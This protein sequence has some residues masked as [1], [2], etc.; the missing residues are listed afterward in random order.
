MLYDNLND[1]QS[2]LLD[3]LIMY[4]GYGVYVQEVRSNE[5][6]VTVIELKVQRPGR[7]AK[8]EWVKLTDP[9]LRYM[10]LTVGY[11]NYNG[12]SKWFYRHPVRQYR[13]GLRGEQLGGRDES[14]L[15]V[16][17]NIRFNDLYNKHSC[18]AEML[19]NKYPTIEEATKK[20]SDG[21]ATKVGFHKNFALYR[22]KFRKD[23]V[24]EYK[25]RPIAVTQ[26]VTGHCEPVEE[27]RFLREELQRAGIKVK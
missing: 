1:A 21:T 24:V 5:E 13:Q 20:V 11:V 2:K 26:D 6:D 17:Y 9:K 19:E 22:D 8:G 27:F 15:R 4:D 23:F 10:Q 12:E 3:T 18:W 7:G 16:E 25:G 14:G